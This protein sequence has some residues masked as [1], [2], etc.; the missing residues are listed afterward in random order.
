MLL[1]TQLVTLAAI[2]ATAVIYGTDVFSAVVLRPALRDLSDR[3]MVTTGGAIHHYGDQRLPLPGVTGAVAALLAAVLAGATG[4]YGA[5]C[6]A[7]IAFLCLV[8]W[9][10]LYLRIAAPI[11]KTL[12]V[13]SETGDIP[14]RARA[15]QNRWDS[16]I[17]ARAALQGIAVAGLGATLIL[18]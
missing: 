17:G 3:D 1:L 18:L 5:A 9:V 2:L 7:G 8:T 6:A 15:L 14:D 13:A 4:E 12:R 11:N 16:I 10:V